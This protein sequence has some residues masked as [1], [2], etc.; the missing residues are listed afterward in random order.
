MVVTLITPQADCLL[1]FSLKYDHLS[2][3]TTCL[4]SPALSALACALHGGS[5]SRSPYIPSF[6]HFNNVTTFCFTIV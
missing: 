2:S 6:P 5:G 4:C 3:L 1:D